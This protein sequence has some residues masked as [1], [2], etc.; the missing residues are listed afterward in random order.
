MTVCVI[1]N[2]GTVYKRYSEKIKTSLII[3][4]EKSAF[5]ELMLIIA[6]RI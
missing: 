3:G 6:P 5:N 4:H 2:E 1:N